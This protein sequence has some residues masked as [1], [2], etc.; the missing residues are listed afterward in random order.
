MQFTTEAAYNLDGD[1]VE[2]LGLDG[3]GR[4]LDLTP[5]SGNWI[6]I[7][8]SEEEAEALD[9]VPT[10]YVD[11][12]EKNDAEAQAAIQAATGYPFYMAPPAEP[13]AVF[14]ALMSEGDGQPHALG[15]FPTK[16]EAI[17][18]CAEAADSPGASIAIARNLTENEYFFDDDGD[19]WAWESVT[20]GE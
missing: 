18:C 3:S 13:K 17:Q 15:V 16:E 4:G 14:V 19:C 6:I 7:K 12:F 9:A 10:T 11:A 20:L 2:A 8:V 1:Q 5:G